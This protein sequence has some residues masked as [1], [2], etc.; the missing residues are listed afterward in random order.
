[1]TLA[2]GVQEAK[3]KATRK[4]VTMFLIFIDTSLCQERA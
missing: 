2:A 1:M 3:I 4:T